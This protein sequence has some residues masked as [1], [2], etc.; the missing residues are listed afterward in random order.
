MGAQS[1]PGCSGSEQQNSTLEQPGEQ[2]PGEKMGSSEG[3]GKESSSTMGQDS[4][5]T[6]GDRETE[7]KQLAPEQTGKKLGDSSGK[8]SSSAMGEQNNQ[9]AQSERQTRKSAMEQDSSMEQSGK[10]LPQQTMGEA[11]TQ[12][13]GKEKSRGASREKM[14]QLDQ[15]LGETSEA[16]GGELSAEQL[17]ALQRGSGPTMGEEAAESGTTTQSGT[18]ASIRN[19]RS[20][21]STKTLETGVG[22]G[23]GETEEE[24]MELGQRPGKS[25]KDRSIAS[26]IKVLSAKDAALGI[27]KTKNKLGSSEFNKGW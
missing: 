4:A 19:L 13:P 7:Q 20:D 14:E 10:E 6:P 21:E 12:S 1:K 8:D 22:L 27:G 15:A 16:G 17:S 5:G 23:E 25:L 3:A 2:S 9:L 26:L 11:G 18:E 24:K